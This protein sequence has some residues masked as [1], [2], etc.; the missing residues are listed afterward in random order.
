MNVEIECENGDIEII[1][2]DITTY[3][4]V[5]LN[6]LDKLNYYECYFNAIE[7]INGKLSLFENYKI[8]KN[9]IEITI[10]IKE[11]M[12]SIFDNMKFFDNEPPECGDFILVIHSPESRCLPY[13]CIYDAD[14]DWISGDAY[15]NLNECVDAFQQIE[16]RS[17]IHK[18]YLTDEYNIIYGKYWGK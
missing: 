4:P 3:V 11:K 6:D 13:T 18:K 7:R 5:A 9:Y 16:Y 2:E 8:L 14:V 1:N 12:N 17:Y 15:I 10:L